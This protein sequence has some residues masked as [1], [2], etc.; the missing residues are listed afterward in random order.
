MSRDKTVS[1]MLI[2]VERLILCVKHYFALKFDF[3]TW[4]NFFYTTNGCDVRDKYQVWFYTIFMQIF[5]LQMLV[6]LLLLRPAI[7]YC[8]VINETII[9][10]ASLATNTLHALARK[11]H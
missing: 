6:L 2:C 4:L 7:R 1:K 5:F 8:V 11:Q 10:A 9:W 3:F